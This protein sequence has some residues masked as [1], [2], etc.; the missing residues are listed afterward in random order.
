MSG[1]HN[2][3]SVVRAIKMGAFDFVEKPLTLEKIL[4]IVGEALREN[5]SE[6]ANI[7]DG[8]CP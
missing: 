6:Q 7:G 1:H 2:V 8:S 5:L 4:Q 3:E